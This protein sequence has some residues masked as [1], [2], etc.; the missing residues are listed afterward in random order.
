MERRDF[1]RGVSVGAWMASTGLFPSLSHGATP[2]TRQEGASTM[3]ESTIMPEQTRQGDMIYR[4][5]GRTGERVSLVGLGGYHIGNPGEAE[6]LRIIRAAIDRGVNF[7]DN[8]WDYH[9]GESERR[10]GQALRDGYR[11]KVLLM[12]KIDGR[13][14][15]AAAR[16]L[17]ESLR[18]LGVE[19][20]DLMQ[21]HEI[22]RVE[23]PDRIFAEDGANQALLEARRAGK[24]RYIG[25]TGHKDPFIHLRMLEVA[26]SHGFR[27]DAVQLP[28]NV[29]D[30]HF[31]SF[32]EQV[33]PVLVRQQIGVL[34][35]KPL[36]S[37]DILKSGAGVSATECLHYAMH[38]PT[39]V[40]ITGIESMENLEQALEAVRTFRPLNP[41][42]VTQLLAR[43]RQY[44][45]S[46]QHEKFKTSTQFDATAQN[47][48]WL[49]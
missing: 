3:P 23:D 24:I 26:A 14:K 8:S 40:V 18:R 29:M 22:I 35:M 31:R 21:H 19:T 34:G 20:I 30:A 2:E 11:D 43:T 13:T 44:A 48:Q 46:G 37:G 32:G 25:F 33:L 12:S 4:A 9:E 38:R 41:G 49:G 47:P 10:M 28:I 42:E 17:D 1:L 16:Q 15:A 7:M 6:G 5:L 39:S 36:A 45:L 27:F